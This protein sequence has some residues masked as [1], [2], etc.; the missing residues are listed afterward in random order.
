LGPRYLDSGS[1]KG[2]VKKIILFL[3]QLQNCKTWIDNHCER[4]EMV[5]DTHEGVQHNSTG[6][7]SG[8]KKKV[9]E[10]SD[11]EKTVMERIRRIYVH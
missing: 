8:K 6:S 1:F 5:R 9:W 7:E 2:R 11:F 4:E 3:L 10:K